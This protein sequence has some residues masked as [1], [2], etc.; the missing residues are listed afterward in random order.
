LHR[1]TEKRAHQQCGWKH[2]AKDEGPSR[3]TTI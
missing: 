1:V 3:S 2:S